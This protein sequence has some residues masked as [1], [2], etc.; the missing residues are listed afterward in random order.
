[1]VHF[2]VLLMSMLWVGSP[3]AVPV[4]DDLSKIALFRNHS[5]NCTVTEAQDQHLFHLSTNE[6]LA[7]HFDQLEKLW[8]VVKSIPINRTIIE[9]S[10]HSEHYQHNLVSMCDIFVLPREIECSCASVQQVGHR[11]AYCTIL[12]PRKGKREF[13]AQEF[14]LNESTSTVTSDIDLK[15]ISCIAGSM[16]GMVRTKYAQ[17]INRNPRK[18]SMPVVFQQNYVRLADSIMRHL[19]M[20]K[21][22]YT[23]AHWRRGDQLTT[24]CIEHSRQHDGSVNC[25]S[26]QEFIATVQERKAER[27]KRVKRKFRV[28]VATNEQD[29]QVLHELHS[30]GF[31][32]ATNIT[33]ALQPHLQLSEL[34][35]FVVELLILC[36]AEKFWY[37]GLSTVHDL[38]L[39]CREKGV[40]HRKEKV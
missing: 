4:S 14:G 5:S 6:G 10:F 36:E 23:A 30:A 18:L 28:Y 8:M 26:V 3:K 39:R 1:M 19:Q 29:P 27:K 15:N 11:E 13:H 34:E 25:D 33:T 31:L 17:I 9:T 7:S 16:Y 12:M 37:W 21:G 35:L 38:V 20:Q 32:T 2:L 22:V 40:L 24:R